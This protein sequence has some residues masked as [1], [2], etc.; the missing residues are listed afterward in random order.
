M[1]KHKSPVAG[2]YRGLLTTASPWLLPQGY[3]PYAEN[4][5]FR[6]G[7]AATVGKMF[8]RYAFST[9]DG[10]VL[11][12]KNILRRD[13]TTIGVLIT[14]EAVYAGSATSWTKISDA[15]WWPSG[16]NPT[17]VSFTHLIAYGVEWFVIVN[18]MADGLFKWDCYTLTAGALANLSMVGTTLDYARVKYVDNYKDRLIFANIQDS[19]THNARPNV[20]AWGGTTGPFDFAGATGAGEK[21]MS[22]APGPITGL[23]KIQDYLAITTSSAITLATYTGDTFVYKWITTARGVGCTQARAMQQLSNGDLLVFPARDNIYLF[24]GQTA[25]RIG[26]NVLNLYKAWAK[27]ND[28]KTTIT[29]L[30][31][32]LMPAFDEYWMIFDGYK[33]LAWNYDEEA[34][35]V[36]KFLNDDGTPQTIRA[37]SEGYTELSGMVINDLTFP[38]NQITQLINALGGSVSSD[39]PVAVMDDGIYVPELQS[40]N[41]ATLLWPEARFANNVTITRFIFDVIAPGGGT[42]RCN[43]TTNGGREL[44]ASEDIDLL[45]TSGF[46]TLSQ[47][48]GG[49]QSTQVFWDKVV[50]SKSFQLSID[51]AGQP[52]IEIISID[53]DIASAEPDEQGEEEIYPQEGENEQA[54]GLFFP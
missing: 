10:T 3:F 46:P 11:D 39:V 15:S 30:T 45:A 32:C 23:M 38:I 37:M 6:Y 49:V 18:N 35:A 9:I 20:F 13:G 14:D 4:F 22:D 42:F 53:A 24:D 48:G 25:K 7:R 26:G 2:P 36:F 40:T 19:G 8:Q 47:A 12:Y 33:V 44:V 34:W 28:A 41:R 31:S 21:V 17:E 5:R 29:N 16:I 51:V 52:P 1:A 27:V 54:T 43:L 50:T